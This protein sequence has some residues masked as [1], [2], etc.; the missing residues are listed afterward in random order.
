[1][2]DVISTM[3]WFMTTFLSFFNGNSMGFMKALGGKSW[4]FMQA[5]VAVVSLCA[6]IQDS[7][8]ITSLL[9]VHGAW[10]VPIIR[11]MSTEDTCHAGH[12]CM[13]GIARGVT[14]LNAAIRGRNYYAGFGVT[15]ASGFLVIMGVGNEHNM[16]TLIMSLAGLVL[17][18]FR[19]YINDMYKEWGNSWTFR[20]VLVF[21]K[22]M[23]GYQSFFHPIPSKWDDAPFW[24]IINAVSFP[25]GPCRGTDVMAQKLYNIMAYGSVIVGVLIIANV[26]LVFIALKTDEKTQKTDLEQKKTIKSLERKVTFYE[27]QCETDQD[28]KNVTTAD[29]TQFIQSLKDTIE[30]NNRTMEEDNITITEL[31]DNNRKLREFINARE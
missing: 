18:V 6:G 11:F 23:L 14:F 7:E 15:A 5:G 20:S 1:M 9:G 24:T 31:H 17:N 12:Y 21:S 4:N 3:I 22:F 2:P 30:K 10:F 13:M 25:C 27:D 26:I 16:S 19:S 29:N 8:V 28:K